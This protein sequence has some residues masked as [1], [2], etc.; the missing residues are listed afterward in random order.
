MHRHQHLA[1]RKGD[2]AENVRMDCV[3][4]E[5]M[6]NYFFKITRHGLLKSPSQLYNIDKM[7]MPLDHCPPKVV[8]V[9]GQKKV[10]SRTSGNKSQI[11]VIACASAAGHVIPPFIIF[12]AQGL[13]YHWTVGEVVGTRYGLSSN[14]LPVETCCGE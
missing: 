7:G 5:V 1:L 3:D 2:S 10:R 12:D 9:R 14:R 13:N 8:T 11:M 6:K 4:K